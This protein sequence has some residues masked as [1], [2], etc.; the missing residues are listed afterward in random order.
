MRYDVAVVGAG[1][2][3]AAAARA[4]ASAGARV[5]LFEQFDVGHERGSSHG[6]SRIFRLSY[7]DATYVRMAQRALPLWR[8][9]ERD[10][11]ATLLTVT[12]GYDVGP[13]ID[14]NAAALGACDAPFEILDGA[15][16]ARRARTVRFAAAE[17]VLFQPDAG[18]VAADATVAACVAL[19]ADA[20]A[21]VRTRTRVDALRQLD[22]G[23]DVVS[24]DDVARAGV[25]VV[26]AGAWARRLLAPL[27]IELTVTPTRET[28]AYFRVDERVPALVEWSQPA[29]YALPAPG[30][31]VKAGEHHAGPVADPDEPGEISGASVERIAAW[32]R[33]RMPGAAPE[34][35]HAETC[36]YTNTPDERFVVER[37]GDV[38][39]GSACSGHGFKFAPLTGASLAAL[40]GCGEHP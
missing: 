31:G 32:V 17:R 29:R 2:A 1:M 13:G 28:V 9:L 34:P 36:L 38:V 16:A 6:T 39:V 5:V 4:A 33:D 26:A 3:G 20:G 19:A 22:S 21:D 11:R 35:H 14:A 10:A 12:G 24:G 40:A 30:H 8:A 18:I 27:G 23:V 7:P 15:A 37:F 25:A